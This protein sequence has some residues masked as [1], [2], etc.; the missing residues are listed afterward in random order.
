MQRH[1]QSLFTALSIK[2]S[3]IFVKFRQPSIARGAVLPVA[4]ML[5]LITGMVGIAFVVYARAT[6]I[7]GLLEKAALTSRVIA[8][9]AA[10]AVWKFDNQAGARIL[11]S[12]SS[13]PDFVSGI[14]V[15]DKN[16]LFAQFARNGSPPARMQST[17]AELLGA[18][19]K[20]G[21]LAEAREFT[22]VNEVVAMMPLVLPGNESGHVGYIAFSFSADR[23][24]AA[25]RQ[26]VLVVSATGLV[27]LSFIC[28][29]LGWILTRVTR[30]IRDMTEVISR[31]HF[32][33]STAVM[34]S[35]PWRVP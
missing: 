11:Q 4:G 2:W 30:P 19:M 27:S 21:E 9:N 1:G 6:A 26:Q 23:V 20:N 35:A 32:R 8:P 28:A 29:L 15:D 3:W 17:I 25:I 24:H 7:A 5:V 34:R 10:A 13:D 22:T 33:H 12:L 14:I 18:D 16:G 31:S